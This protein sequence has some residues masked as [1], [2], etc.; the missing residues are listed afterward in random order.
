MDST[1]SL[2]R[3]EVKL[4]V[5]LYADLFILIFTNC[6]LAKDH[7]EYYLSELESDVVYNFTHLTPIGICN[8][9]KFIAI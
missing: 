9:A 1:L 6:L 7:S 3:E 2:K 4:Q 5:G 8:Y